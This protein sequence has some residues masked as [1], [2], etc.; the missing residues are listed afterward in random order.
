MHFDPLRCLRP[1][2]VV[3][4]DTSVAT[5]NCPNTDDDE[6]PMKNTL[7]WLYLCH[8]GNSLNTTQLEVV[9]TRDVGAAAGARTAG[10]MA[11]A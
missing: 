2:Q 5:T 9:M 8:D 3:P 7:P 11:G 6:M 10:T 4:T 1:C